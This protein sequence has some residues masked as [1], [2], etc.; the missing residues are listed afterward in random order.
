MIDQFNY[1]GFNDLCIYP[2][3][4]DMAFYK[5]PK[6]NSTK[7]GFVYKGYTNINQ[8]GKLKQNIEY[9]CHIN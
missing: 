4:K 1:Y 8:T 9:F 7:G 2:Q 6:S 5:D 3:D